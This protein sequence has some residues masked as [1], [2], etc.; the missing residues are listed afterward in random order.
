MVL[1]LSGFLVGSEVV[2]DA[3]DRDEIGLPVVAEPRLWDAGHE[4]ASGGDEGSSRVSGG[5]ILYQDSVPEGLVG[6]LG[7]GKS[8]VFQSGQSRA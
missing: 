8:L 1:T 7:F 6:K 4:M 3:I 5:I 2:A